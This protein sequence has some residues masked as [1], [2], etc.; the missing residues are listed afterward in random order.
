MKGYLTELN[1]ACLSRSAQRERAGELAR[2]LTAPA[3]TRLEALGAI[4]DFVAKS[5]REAGPSFTELPLRE[6]SAADVTLADGYGH[7]ADRAILLR[8]MLAAAGFEPEIV[9]A[10]DLP[11]IA[12]ITNVVFSF[13]LPDAFQEPLVRCRV[14]GQDYYLNDTDQYAKLGSTSADGRLGLV[15]GSGQWEVIRAARDCGDKMETVYTLSPD[16]EGKTRIGVTHRYYGDNYNAM[17]RYFA[18]LPPEE[19]RRY[20]QEIVSG[21][22]QG[23]RPVGGLKTEFDTYPGVEEFTVEVDHYSVVDGNYFYFDMPFKPS[24]LPVGA[25]RRTLPLF[26]SGH[27]ASSVRTEIDWPAGFHRLIMAP[28]SETLDEPDGAGEARITSSGTESKWVITHEFETSPAIVEPNDYAAML[29][30]E[31]ALGRKGSKVFLLEKD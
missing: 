22:A 15:L 9:L 14:E 25:D 27:A 24:L 23:A 4:R 1:E 10:S 31:S 19:R 12:G 30:V 18:E 7:A 8:A 16:D 3:K 17:H 13:P 2:Q 29:K 11:P 26:L 28:K 5:I 6:L 20:F 21:V